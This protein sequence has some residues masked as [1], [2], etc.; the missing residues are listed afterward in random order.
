[1]DN[2][3]LVVTAMMFFNLLWALYTTFGKEKIMIKQGEGAL[4]STTYLFIL[5]RYVARIV[6]FIVLL[7]QLGTLAN[8]LI[9]FKLFFLV[10]VATAVIELL[11][12]VV[13]TII[14]TA[15]FKITFAKKDEK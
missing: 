12:A 11:S 9:G 3:V 7:G 5:I 6:G 10:F 15:M 4:P 2:M 13:E 1:M 8:T 14:R